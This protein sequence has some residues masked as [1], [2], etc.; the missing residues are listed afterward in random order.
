MELKD[1]KQ[2]LLDKTFVS[3]FFIFIDEKNDNFLANQYYIEI[4]KLQELEIEYIQDI[5]A[6]LYRNKQ[7]FNNDS[8]N[9]MRKL[10]IYNLFEEFTLI[11]D[12]L[13]YIDNLI[14]VAPTISKEAKEIWKDNLIIFPQLEAWQVEDY[15]KMIGEG[16]EEKDI[17][18]I[19]QVCNYNIFRIKNELDKINILPKG[20]RKYIVKDMINEGAFGD[21]STYNLFNLT[22][23]IQTKN[24]DEL[25]KILS[26]MDNLN[27]EPMPFIYTLYQNFRKML[28]VWYNPNPTLENT[29]GLK[30]NQ[31]WAIKNLP[32]NYTKEQIIEIFKFLT[33]LDC[34]LKKGN[35]PNKQLVKYII[36]KIICI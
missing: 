16:V 10:H 4:A 27:I 25:R 20:Q 23:A 22:N 5:N 13:K 17:K 2:S 19:T 1:L 26:Q 15:A 21:L 35:L 6:F 7:I 30:G 8:N 32:R 24:K 11:N 18:Y 36:A 14:I 3:K 34:E 9:N 31:I 33:T 12:E 29:G 28:M